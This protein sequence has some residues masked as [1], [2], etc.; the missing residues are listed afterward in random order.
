MKPKLIKCADGYKLEVGTETSGLTD[1]GQPVQLKAGGK[2][3]VAFVDLDEDG[4]ECYTPLDD[5]VYVATPVECDEEDEE[6]EAE[7]EEI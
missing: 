4:E 1:Y 7:P 2:L 5:L 6:S 3:Y